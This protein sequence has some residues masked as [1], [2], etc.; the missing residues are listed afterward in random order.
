MRS[1]V[2]LTEGDLAGKPSEKLH[3]NITILYKDMV[4]HFFLY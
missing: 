2:V 3:V 1:F 4:L